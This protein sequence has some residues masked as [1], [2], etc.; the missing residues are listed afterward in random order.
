MSEDMM[1]QLRSL[2]IA[3]EPM[4]LATVDAQGAPHAATVYFAPD[5]ALSLY[6]FSDADTLHG[7]HVRDNPS[8]AAAMQTRPHMWQQIRGVQLHGRVEAVTDTDAWN[9]AWQCYEAKFPRIKDVENMLRDLQLYRFT[10]TWVRL[11]DY[12]IHY[13]HE[14]ETDW[15]PKTN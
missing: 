3:I 6:Y 15:P 1:Q 5:E 14:V 10:P 11:I 12:S 8:A 4:T 13:G 9:H 7:R 2:Y